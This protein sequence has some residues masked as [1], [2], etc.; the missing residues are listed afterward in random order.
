MRLKRLYIYLHES[1]RLNEL[2][3]QPLSSQIR[4]HEWMNKAGINAELLAHDTWIR[5][6]RCHRMWIR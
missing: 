1:R 5:L 6:S 4:V 3:K 2:S